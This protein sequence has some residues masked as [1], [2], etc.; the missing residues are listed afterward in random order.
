LVAAV[1]NAPVDVPLMDRLP[2]RFARFL[3][4]C[5]EVLPYNKEAVQLP[6]Q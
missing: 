2:M 5:A 1:M 4:W 6:V 3:R